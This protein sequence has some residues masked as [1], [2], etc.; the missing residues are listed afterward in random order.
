MDVGG[1]QPRRDLRIRLPM[2]SGYPC[3]IYTNWYAVSPWIPLV[4]GMDVAV[5]VAFGIFATLIVP[6]SS[7][8]GGPVAPRNRT[9]WWRQ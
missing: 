6:D 1:R 3:L 9:N 5:I 2:F 4:R 8:S 7:F